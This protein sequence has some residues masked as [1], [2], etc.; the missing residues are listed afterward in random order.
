[1]GADGGP[2]AVGQGLEAPDVPHGV[3]GLLPGQV[4]GVGRAPTWAL[5]GADLHKHA[6]VK[7][8]HEGAVGPHLHALADQAPRDRVEG[9]GHLDVVVPVDP[10]GDVEGQVIRSRWRREQV[11]GLLVGEDLGRS[12]LGGAMRAQTGSG[13]APLGGVALGVDQVHEGLAGEHRAPHMSAVT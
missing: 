3:D 1:M 2:V 4:P 10:G 9:L 12:A 8:P 11:R 5:A 13:G 7:D 6:R